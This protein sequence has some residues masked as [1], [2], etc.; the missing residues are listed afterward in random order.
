LEWL[1]LEVDTGPIN[2]QTLGTSENFHNG[3]AFTNFQ[4]TA[5]AN[6]AICVNDFDH[7][8][9]AN[10]TGILNHQQWPVEAAY[11]NDFVYSNI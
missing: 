5:K 1:T 10:A 9:K 8:V 7:F 11:A 6:I 2:G 4:Y 3:G